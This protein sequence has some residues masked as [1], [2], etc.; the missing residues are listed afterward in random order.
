MDEDEINHDQASSA[1]SSE[2]DAPED[3]GAEYEEPIVTRIK[4][5]HVFA[6]ARSGSFFNV[7]VACAYSDGTATGG[8][9]GGVEP[10]DN[11]LGRLEG[12]EVLR[13]Y[14]DGSEGA[15][16][17]K[18]VPA[19]LAERYRLDR[20][21]EARDQARSNA[22]AAFEDWKT[23]LFRA[24]TIP[25]SAQSSARV[26]NAVAYRLLARQSRTASA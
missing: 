13:C 1:D 17:A 6:G 26:E 11:L 14:L 15:G 16:I 3:D 25:R 21:D 12:Y 4:R 23:R 9:R 10:I 2:E 7:Y 5:H 19:Y 8:K 18:F 20:L 24:K 22:A